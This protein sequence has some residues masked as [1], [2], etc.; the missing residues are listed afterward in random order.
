MDELSVIL[1]ETLHKSIECRIVM[2]LGT[3]PFVVCLRSRDI[4]F[5][6]VH[7]AELIAEKFERCNIWKFD[8]VGTKFTR[9][10]SDDIAAAPVISAT[11]YL[12]LNDTLLAIHNLEDCHEE[13]F[14]FFLARRKE[15]VNLDDD[16]LIVF[17]FFLEGIHL[18]GRL[19]DRLEICIYFLL[20]KLLIFSA[21]QLNTENGA[22]YRNTG[23]KYFISISAEFVESCS[24]GG[25][26]LLIIIENFEK[27]FAEPRHTF[28]NEWMNFH[29]SDFAFTKF[30][31]VVFRAIALSIGRAENSI[32]DRIS[33]YFT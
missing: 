26:A 3:L 4:H 29:F 2:N 27:M 11:N 8:L 24:L 25:L 9:V 13:L 23:S 32:E 10:R 19:D 5:F 16:I 12:R 20:K 18:I 15:F 31:C 33:I 7:I 28:S 17:V 21:R 30:I 14:N 22:E 6:C 1:D